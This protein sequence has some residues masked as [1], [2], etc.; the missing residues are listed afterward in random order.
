M[1]VAQKIIHQSMAEIIINYGGGTASFRGAATVSLQKKLLALLFAGWAAAGVAD[2]ERGE[3]S[4]TNT[5]N[6][7][8]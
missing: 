2:G 7:V 6:N 4:K 3:F 5:E 8:E 1:I